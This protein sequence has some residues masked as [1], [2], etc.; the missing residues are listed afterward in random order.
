MRKSALLSAVVIMALGLVQAVAAQSLQQVAPEKV[1]LS[2]TRL[3]RIRPVIEKYI[4]ENRL[5]GGVGLIVRRGSIAYFETYGMADTEAGKPMRKDA[6]F[7]IFSMTKAVT[8]VAAMTLY[9]EGKFSLNDPL[10]KYLPEFA[11]MKV[12]VEKNNAAGKPVLD[13]TVP[14]EHEITVLDLMRHTSGMNYQGPHDEK[15]ELTYRTLGL[16]PGGGDN[17]PISELVKRLSS[18]PL[19]HQPG[20]VWDY[21]FSIDVLGRF[22][23]VVAGKPLDQVFEE[24]IFKPLHMDDTGF[25]VPESK[26]DRLVTMYLANP[27]GFIKPGPPAYQEP[28]KKNPTLFMGGAGL[29]ST[30]M[31]YVRFVEML[32]NGGELDGVRILGPKTV[33]LMRSDLLGDLPRVGNVL[34]PGYGFGLTFAVN[35][36]PTKSASIESKGEYNWGGAAGTGFWIDPSERMVGVFMMQT[37]GDMGKGRVFE[38]LA[39]QAIIDPEHEPER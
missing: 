5:S 33:A 10:S 15:G 16:N 6:I 21:G 35:R 29:M 13:Y 39:Y 27:E 18:A 26:W 4:A 34:G 22:V 38:R 24:R 25:Y 7:R 11:H 8:G 20:T 36:G 30:A 23:E 31:D 12:A 1:G 2:K 14:V 19:V 28:A 3:D 17:F 37:L 32:L 9:E